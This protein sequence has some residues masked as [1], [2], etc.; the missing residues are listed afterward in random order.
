MNKT[1]PAHK[2]Q[3]ATACRFVLIFAFIAL[4]VMVSAIL[5]F[6]LYEWIPGMVVLLLLLIAGAGVMVAWQQ[7]TINAYQ[8][9]LEAERARHA[10]TEER[11]R[12]TLMSAGDGGIATD[13]QTHVHAAEHDLE[14]SE[15]RYRRLFEAAK[16]GILILDAET[17]AIVDA[18]PFLLDLLGY[19]QEEL[20]GKH[21]W[22]IGL[23]KDIAE[24]KIA[25]AELQAK[26]YVRYEDLPLKTSNG[27]KINVEFVSNIYRVDGQ[28]VIQCNIRDISQRI[29]AEE[30]NRR[31][32]EQRD[33]ERLVLLNILEDQKRA[34]DALKESTTFLDSIVENIP[35]M[36][37]IKDAKE[38][39]FVRLNKAGEEIFGHPRES[40]IGKNDYDFF[41]R[42]QADFFIAK[43]REVLAGKVLLDIPEEPIHA[44]GQEARFLHTKKVP[45]RDAAGNPLY[46]LGISEDVTERKRVLEQIRTLNEE[47]EQR[48]EERTA[49]LAATNKELESFSYSVSH[50]LRAPLRAIDG[51]SRI[52][53]EEHG[54]DINPE[55]AR[56]LQ[57]VR[58]S[59]KQMGVLVDDLLNFSRLSR[60][61]LEK[62]VVH[63]DDLAQRV[64]DDLRSDWSQRDMTFHIGE[65]PACKADA[66]LL[67]QVVVNLLSNALKFTRN[68]PKPSIEVFAM[69]LLAYLEVE[70]DRPHTP[71]DLSL[72][73]PETPI[74]CVRDNGVGFD[75]RYASKLFGVF[76]RLHRAEEYEGTGVGLAIIQ[77]IITRHGGQVWVESIPNAG[78]TFYFTVKGQENEQGGN[79]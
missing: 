32:Q 54:A 30:E 78:T 77:R 21:L 7:N 3:G 19:S 74:Y 68:I 49:E 22:E 14:A 12:A 36:I 10:T 8:A 63:L 2:N 5:Y 56:Y 57:L 59:V 15:I 26:E 1:G 34:R 75:M 33:Q 66:R 53:Q 18:N 76:Q 72:L 42:E 9:L 58:D 47:L 62:D 23:F 50:D 24:S 46:L 45:I 13:D 35:D 51:F 71:V 29:K 64:W 55:G 52:L 40:I 67:R 28:K 41:P 73:M 6:R 61:G 44:Q 65:L 16:D 70:P 31:L 17:G 37:F 27:R 48:V 25:F 39:R 60:Q 4:T 79:R 69:T 20:L 11:S 38:L 43:D